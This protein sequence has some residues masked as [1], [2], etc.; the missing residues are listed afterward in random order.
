[1]IIDLYL[2]NYTFTEIERITNH[3]ETSIKRYLADFIQIATLYQQ[4]FSENQMRVIA[5]MS[6]RIIREYVQ[7]YQTYQRQDN[8]RLQDLLSPQQPGKDAKKKS[9]PDENKGDK[10]HE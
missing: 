3:S 10:N 7:L 2:K 8:Q 6:S 4:K 1:V 5:K 9:K